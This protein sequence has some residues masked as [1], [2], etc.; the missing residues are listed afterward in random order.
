MDDLNIRG[1]LRQYI[2]EELLEDEAPVEDDENLLADGMVSSLGM[3]R[4]VGFI[5]ET[6]GVTVPPDDFTIENFRTIETLDNYLSARV[7]NRTPA[8]DNA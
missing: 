7:D 4:L 3:I 5:E 2:G 6:Y 1:A 8:S